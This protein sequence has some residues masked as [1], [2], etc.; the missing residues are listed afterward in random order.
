MANSISGALMSKPSVG[1]RLSAYSGIGT[2]CILKAHLLC[3]RCSIVSSIVLRSYER[4]V[5][6][7]WET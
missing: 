5:I 1:G 3:V 7:E 4:A 6:H 2:V